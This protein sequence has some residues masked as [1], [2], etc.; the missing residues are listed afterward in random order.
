M[1]TETATMIAMKMMIKTKATAA[2][3][4]AWRLHGGWRGGIAAAAEALLQRTGGSAAAVAAK[5]CGWL[6][7]R[8][9]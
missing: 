1:V 9:Y 3:V 4:A 5:G 2:A 6:T 7:S 8:K